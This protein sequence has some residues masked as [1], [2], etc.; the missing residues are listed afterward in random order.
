MKP[1]TKGALLLVVLLAL[2][3]AVGA[4]WAEKYNTP[5]GEAESDMVLAKKD[6]FGGKLKRPPV[7]FSHRAHHED[8]KIKC[9]QCHHTFED[10]KNIWTPDDGANACE[11]CHTTPY[12]NEGKMPSLYNAFHHLCKDCHKAA[13]AGPQTCDDCHN[14]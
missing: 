9:T 11:D 1:S 12:R 13:K 8:Y 10:G 14:G 5:A 7:P 3:L 2:L 6:A 4:A